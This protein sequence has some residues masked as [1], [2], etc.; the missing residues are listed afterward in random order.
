MVAVGRRGRTQNLSFKLLYS[1]A[2]RC[3]GSIGAPIAFRSG[4]APRV[5]R[6]A[7]DLPD[8]SAAEAGRLST[9]L[10]I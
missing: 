10:L 5:R 6:V 2:L 9:D 4:K 1:K 3:R 8:G 7:A